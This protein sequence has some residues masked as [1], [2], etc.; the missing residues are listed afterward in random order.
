MP[1]ED[2]RSRLFLVAPQ[3]PPPDFSQKFASALAGG[4]IAC[5]LMDGDT[6]DPKAFTNWAAP[7]VQTA[8]SA[9]IAVLVQDD[10]R[11]AGH[12]EADGI[13]VND[14]PG[15][16]PSEQEKLQERG[17]IIG[18]GGLNTRHVALQ[19]GE[20][21]PDYVFFGR[22][23]RDLESDNHPKTETLSV[24]WAQMMT[25]PCVA[26][27]GTSDAAFTKLAEEGVEFVAVRDQ[28]WD[29]ENPGAIVA[30]LNRLLNAAAQKRMEAAA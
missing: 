22:T 23:D 14:G 2:Y 15:L 16:D 8:Q 12:L 17:L 6:T 19:V 28:I 24:W 29:A 27:A 13:H 10:T 11:L 18:T 9:N 7:Y 4:D 30:H 1:L 26:F 5:L 25:I 20:R 3:T 21:E